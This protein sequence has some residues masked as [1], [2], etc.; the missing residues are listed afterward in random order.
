VCAS[1]CEHMVGLAEL[2]PCS[3]YEKVTLVCRFSTGDWS[4]NAWFV[5]GWLFS[6][7]IA[8]PCWCFSTSHLIMLWCPGRIS[9]YVCLLNSEHVA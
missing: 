3:C 4:E 9:R 8:F 7:R 6:V 1:K 2:L 5:S